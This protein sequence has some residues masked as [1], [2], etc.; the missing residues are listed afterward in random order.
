MSDSSN[1]VLAACVERFCHQQ[2]VSFLT[3]VT[4]E[5]LSEAPELFVDDW[6]AS[7]CLQTEKA[8]VDLQVFFNEEASQAV[9]AKVMSAYPAPSREYTGQEVMQECLNVVIGRIKGIIATELKV[10]R[11]K[12][13]FLPTLRRVGTADLT[14]EQKKKGTYSI[15]WDMNWSGHRLSVSCDVMLF[16][17]LSSEVLDYLKSAQLVEESSEEI[18][19]F[20]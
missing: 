8:S 12:K 15:W 3:G 14:R 20:L 17:E 2:A 16:E 18:F 9:L 5:S 7:V 11:G 19:K 6:V 1:H 4:F 10:V 13:T